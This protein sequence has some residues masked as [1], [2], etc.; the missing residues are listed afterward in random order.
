MSKTK[1]TSPEKNLQAT[2]PPALLAQ[3]EQAAEAEHITVDELV[4]DAVESRLDRKEWQEIL[5][6]GERHAQARHLTESDVEEAI[7]AVRSKDTE[8][9]R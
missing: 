6:F 3:I 5:L 1:A 2:V 8:H 4:Q 7:S 9:W